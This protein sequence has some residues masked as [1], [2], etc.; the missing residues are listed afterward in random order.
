ME[1]VIVIKNNINGYLTSYGRNI[2]INYMQDVG[3]Y[4]H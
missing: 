1:D 3:L 2:S 4:A